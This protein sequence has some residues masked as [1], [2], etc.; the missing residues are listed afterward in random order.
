MVS[1]MRHLSHL[2][3]FAGLF[4]RLI[5][6][7]IGPAI[8]VHKYSSTPI[9]PLQKATSTAIGSAWQLQCVSSLA[10]PFC[11]FPFRP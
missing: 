8:S 5:W 7:T 10:P 4:V 6:N 2:W 1:D 11:H 3:W 9:R